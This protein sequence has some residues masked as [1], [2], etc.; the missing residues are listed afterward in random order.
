MMVDTP[1]DTVSLDVA[2]RAVLDAVRSGELSE[3]RID[4]S[5]ARVIALKRRR[6]L[7]ARPFVSPRRAPARLGT[8]AHRAAAR[9]I[10]G[11]SVTLV[12][13]DAGV[14][15]LRGA[16]NV[17]VAGYSSTTTGGTPAAHLSAALRAQRLPTELVETGAIPD[18]ATIAGAAS[19]AAASDVVVVATANASGSAAQ[20]AL[21][22]ALTA[23]GKP[24]VV[25]ATRNPYDLAQLPGTST[26]VASYSWAAPAMQAVARLLTGRI[27]PA[28]R[29]PVRI[30]AADG[31][32]LYRFG[33]GLGF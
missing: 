26:Y 24:V 19:R 12:R 2:Y 28:G 33:H 7:F 8:R 32:T 3:R 14:L 13:N 16:P 10:A 31:T 23:T 22:E 20:R 25:V 30:P 27:A 11:R 15:P 5:V 1:T 4:R 9:R 17:L 21:V 6:G 29:L 18:A